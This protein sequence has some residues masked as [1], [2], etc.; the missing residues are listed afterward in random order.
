M[1]RILNIFVSNFHN[2]I[3]NTSFYWLSISLRVK[4]KLIFKLNLKI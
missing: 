3:L 1:N 4:I 2:K